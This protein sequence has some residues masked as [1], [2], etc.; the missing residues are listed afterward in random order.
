MYIKAK[1]PNIGKEFFKFLYVKIFFLS[2]QNKKVNIIKTKKCQSRKGVLP[3]FPAQKAGIF[4]KF[5]LVNQPTK[6]GWNGNTTS[7]D[8]LNILKK[9]SI[10]KFIIEGS[11]PLLPI[12]VMNDN[13]TKKE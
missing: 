1:N 4:W 7:I 8:S 5:G 12:N 11:T 10:E 6:W 2:S 3:G 9:F 13:P